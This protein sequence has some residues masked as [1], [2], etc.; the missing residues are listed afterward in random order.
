MSRL[1]VPHPATYNELT[2]EER[3]LIALF[4]QMTGARKR[5]LLEALEALAEHTR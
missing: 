1:S 2:P 5:L 3:R 4:R